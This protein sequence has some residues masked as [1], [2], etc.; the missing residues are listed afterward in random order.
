M[1][2]NLEAQAK[3]RTP[4]RWERDAS[5]RGTEVKKKKKE[6]KIKVLKM[7]IWG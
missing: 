1:L 4:P 3:D 7:Q 2:G 5:G 6:R